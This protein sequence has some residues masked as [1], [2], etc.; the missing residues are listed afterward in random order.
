[1]LLVNKMKGIQTEDDEPGSS[2]VDQSSMTA[3][4]SEDASDET[5]STEGSSD[6]DEED[7]ADD[8]VAKDEEEQTWGLTAL[9]ETFSP[10]KAV[11]NTHYKISLLILLVD[12]LLKFSLTYLHRL[13]RMITIKS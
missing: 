3:D 9:I 12:Q 13:Q 4:E 10:E 6:T 11:R 5:S 1:M 2:S 7:D 8:D